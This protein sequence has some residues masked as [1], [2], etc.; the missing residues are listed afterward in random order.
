M[1]TARAILYG[2]L[3]VGTLDGLDAIVFFG[4]RGASPVRIFQSI[5]GGLLGRA[6]SVSGGLPTAALGLVLHY[7][8][9]FVIVTTFVLASKR[10]TVLTRHPIWSG[11]LY[12]VGVY[13]VMNLI[14]IPL[15][16]LGR[17]AFVLPV[18]ANGVLIHMFGV[19]LPSSLFARAARGGV[20]DGQPQGASR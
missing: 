6:A 12:G 17:G 13:L 11:L 14:V 9:A 19:G 5:A 18:V 3:T 10:L 15:S 4:L 8:I 2:T 20:G 16:A 7:F 1:S